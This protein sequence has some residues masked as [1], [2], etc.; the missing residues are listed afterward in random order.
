MKAKVHTLWKHSTMWSVRPELDNRC[1]RKG[2][3]L[4]LQIKGKNS[5]GRYVLFFEMDFKFKIYLPVTYLFLL[6]YNYNTFQYIQSLDILW[7]MTFLNNQSVTLIYAICSSPL[8]LTL[9][10]K[11]NQLIT[12]KLMMKTWRD[13]I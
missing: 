10:L 12:P 11:L 8:H 5:D 6:Q 2:F 13:C 9:D 7:Q 3:R 1:R 4:T